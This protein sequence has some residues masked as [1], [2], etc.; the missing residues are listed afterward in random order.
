M[1]NINYFLFIRLK[2]FIILFVKIPKQTASINT[3]IQDKHPKI[4]IK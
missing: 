4:F 3:F 1:I 2:I